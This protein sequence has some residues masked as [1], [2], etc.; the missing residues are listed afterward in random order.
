MRFVNRVLSYRPG[1]LK[2]LEEGCASGK[3]MG[4]TGKQV[5]HPSQI[6][7]AQRS[8]RPGHS[9]VEWA[10]RVT[11]ADQKATSQV[12]G[13]WRLDGNMIDVPVARKAQAI[14]SKALEEKWASQE[15][16]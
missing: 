16:Q 11:L 8:F 7:M 6:E 4:F 14:I 13:A 5:I 12:K 2:V 1:G 3:G 10:V 9:R 15:P